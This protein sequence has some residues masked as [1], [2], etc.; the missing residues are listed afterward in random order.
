VPASAAGAR[1]ASAPVSSPRQLAGAAA[2]CAPGFHQAQA[3]AP[4]VEQQ[5]VPELAWPA[6]SVRAQAVQPEPL[7]AVE[8]GWERS[9]TVRR[10]AQAQPIG[11]VQRAES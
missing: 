5:G 11:R 7:A 10:D 9:K 2:P 1:P 6:S 8:H 3:D 4:Q